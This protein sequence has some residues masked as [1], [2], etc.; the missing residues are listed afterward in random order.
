M[1]STTANGRQ[2]QFPRHFIDLTT[3][4]YLVGQPPLGILRTEREIAKR[5]LNDPRLM[6]IPVAF[7]SNQLFVLEHEDA[8]LVLQ[9]YSPN[10]PANA[11]EPTGS[12]GLLSALKSIIRTVARGLIWMAPTYSRE[13]LHWTMF[14]TMRLLRTIRN[15]A[16]N[17]PVDFLSNKNRLEAGPPNDV[18]NRILSQLSIAV[19]L[20]ERDILW[21]CGNCLPLRWVAEQKR[22]SR[23]RVV[24]MA[25]DIIRVRYPEW[26]PPDMPQD[27]FV[28]QTVDLIDAADLIFCNSKNT[29][30]DLTNFAVEVKRS[31]LRSKLVRLG[32]DL[33]LRGPLSG[34]ALD[35][36]FPHLVGKRFALAVGTVEARKNYALLIEIWQVLC[37]EI[38]FNL[39][40]VII[41]RPGVGAATSIAE[42]RMSPLLGKRIFWLEN[43]PDICLSAF[44]SRC[45]MVLCP[46]L[47]EGWGLPVAEAL[48]HGKQVVCSDRGALPEAAMGAATILDATDRAAWTQVIRSVAKDPTGPS[49]TIGMPTWNAAADRICRGLIAIA[50]SGNL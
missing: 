29:R 44:Y 4:L 7:W 37:N 33:P 12:R 9:D 22:L 3:S 11:P 8:D 42:I 2:P 10:L 27:L 45:S 15:R 14:F 13:D 30:R 41:G 19:R 39:D 40:L 5:L 36:E 20:G 32:S 16:A 48:A 21:T 35:H 17:P 24:A 47:M 23:F 28:A 18:R 26:N 25:H 1:H 38:T 34:E 50:H 46:S 6:S 31:G 49:A 43:C